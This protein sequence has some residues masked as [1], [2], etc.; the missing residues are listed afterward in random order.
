MN[1][2]FTQ[3]LVPLGSL[4]LTVLVAFVPLFILLALLAGF[5]AP[6]INSFTLGIGLGLDHGTATSQGPG[7]GFEY[8]ILPNWNVKSEYLYMDFGTRQSTN[9]DGDIFEHRN[10]VQT[11]KVGLNYRWGGSRLAGY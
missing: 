5:L 3:T 4:W 2:S 6:T 11:W 7:S 10:R 8:A 1:P 9:I